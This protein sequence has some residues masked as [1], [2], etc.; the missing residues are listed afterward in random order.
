MPRRISKVNTVASS[1][2]WNVLKPT[3]TLKRPF[4]EPPRPDIIVMPS[5]SSMLPLV[6]ARIWPPYCPISSPG[7]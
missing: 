2:V 5:M 7:M 6:E 3:G 4:G 1:F